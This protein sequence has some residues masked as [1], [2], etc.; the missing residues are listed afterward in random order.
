MG[1]LRQ[2]VGVVGGHAEEG[3]GCVETGEGLIVRQVV[4]VHFNPYK[5]TTL[6]TSESVQFSGFPF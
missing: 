4:D 5:L 1:V 3:G 6:G 2:V